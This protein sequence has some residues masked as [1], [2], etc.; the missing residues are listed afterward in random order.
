MTYW[1]AES[2]ALIL[3]A[4]SSLPAQN[5][6]NLSLTPYDENTEAT[7]KCNDEADESGMRCAD[8]N[9]AA[10]IVYFEELIKLQEYCLQ[11]EVVAFSLP[12]ASIVYVPDEDTTTQKHLEGCP[13]FSPCLSTDQTVEPAMH[14]MPNHLKKALRQLVRWY[15]ISTFEPNCIMG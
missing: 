2:R 4:K 13:C 12:D 10:K 9:D 8:D 1:P 14:M 5:I 15:A 7:L 6:A 11:N 3:G